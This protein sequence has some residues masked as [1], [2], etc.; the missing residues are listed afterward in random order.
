MNE[1]QQ[2]EANYDKAKENLE[3][4]AA[5][6]ANLTIRTILGS[7]QA[8]QSSADTN[9]RKA[10]TALAKSQ[11]DL[12]K[13]RANLERA[14]ANCHRTMLALEEFDRAQANQ[15]RTQSSGDFVHNVERP[16]AKIGRGKKSIGSFSVPHRDDLLAPSDKFARALLVRHTVTLFA[17]VLAFLQYY[18]LDARLQIERLPTGV[19]YVADQQ[20]NPK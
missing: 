10:V 8:G 6:L 1:R 14:R 13:A 11:V 19:A 17:L 2:L 4:A 16:Q 9:L 18:L 15:W 12:P 7:P 3:N 20:R 5:D